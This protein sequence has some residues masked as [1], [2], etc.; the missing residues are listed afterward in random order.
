MNPVPETD[1]TIRVLVAEDDASVRLAVAEAIRREPGM[2][3]V[4]TAEDADEAISVAAREQPDVAVID[5][6]MPAGGGSRA[7]REIGRVSPATRVVALSAHDDR[8]SVAEMLRAG[9]L[10][11]VVKGA[12]IG[13]LLEAIERAKRGLASLSGTAAASVG[14]EL[15]ERLAQ[16]ERRVADR[17]RK[18][19]EVRAALGPGGIVPVFQPIMDLV[20]RRVVGYEALA[21][22]QVEPK[23]PPDQW[24]ADAVEVGLGIDLEFAAI[25]A[26]LAHFD[27]LSPEVYLSLNLSPEACLSE[28]LDA[29]LMG[30]PAQRIV[31]EITEHAPVPDYDLLRSALHSF[32]AE[33]GRLAID[34]AG[35]GFAS[36]RHIVRLEP[37]LIKVDIS[38]THDVDW[39]RPRR[40]LTTALVAF[41]RE[42]GIAIV[43]EGIETVAELE[44]LEEL[45]VRAGQGY[46]LGRPGPLPA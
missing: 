25:D 3:V 10:S 22:F 36:L 27:E 13:E 29:A 30:V 43:A 32:R 18:I 14:R 6:R 45:G 1:V 42:M 15:D 40:A 24:F 38:L 41:A 26:A 33:G 35:A 7:T 8:A 11:Y 46:L 5:A 19:E 17:S 12:P 31:L 21:R 37:D 39:D 44:A 34:D 23:R 2:V 20:T 28:R 16:T 4:G 9:A